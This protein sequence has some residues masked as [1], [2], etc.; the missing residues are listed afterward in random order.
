MNGKLVGKRKGW[1]VSQDGD[2]LYFLFLYDFAFK[3]W[4]HTHVTFISTP[5][6]SLSQNM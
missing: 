4:P 6:F 3:R 5:H 1:H 2:F